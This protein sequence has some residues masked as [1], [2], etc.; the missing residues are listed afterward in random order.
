VLNAVISQLAFRRYTKW[1]CKITMLSV[2]VYISEPPFQLLVQLTNVREILYV[3]YAIRNHP[4][5]DCHSPAIINYK[6]GEVVNA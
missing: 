4:N 5:A 3:R 2:G 6:V 1:V